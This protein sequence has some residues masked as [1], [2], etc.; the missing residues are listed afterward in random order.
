MCVVYLAK[1]IIHG[2]R[3][4]QFYQS[5][6]SFGPVAR[7]SFAVRFESEYLSDVRGLEQCRLD[8][9]RVNGLNPRPRTSIDKTRFQGKVTPQ[10]D[11]IKSR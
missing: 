7:T 3:K 10:L 2:P 9:A 11:E 1:K 6:L 4:L 8:L 5:S